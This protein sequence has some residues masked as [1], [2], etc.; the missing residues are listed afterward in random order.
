MSDLF[1]LTRIFTESNSPAIVQSVENKTFLANGINMLRET[2]ASIFEATV[3]LYSALLEAESTAK[4]NQNFADFFREYKNIINKYKN[5]VKSLAS[6]FVIN[7]ET[8]ADANKDILTID[9][10]ANVMALPTYVGVVYDNLL[11][12]EV[13]K[14]EPYKAFK[15]E[16]AFIGKLLQD[17]GPVGSE[18]AKAQVIATVCNNLTKEIEDGWLDKCIK[19]MTD[20]D[21][22]N[23]DGFAKAMYSKFVKD[24]SSEMKIDIGLV[25]QSKLAI[26]NYTSYIETISKSVEDFCDGLDK[27][28]EEIGSLF[29]RNKDHKL[30]IKTDVEGV[31][32]KTYRLNE[33]SFNQINT[34]ITTKISQT[35]ELCN[36]YLIALSIKMDCIYKYLQQCKDI[37]DTANHGVDNTPNTEEDPG[38]TG[39]DQ[40]DDTEDD[41]APIVNEEEPEDNLDDFEVPD[42]SG[43]ETADLSDSVQDNS[44]TEVETECYLFEAEIFQKER[45]VNKLI[46]DEAVL[47]LIAEDQSTNMVGAMAKST[48]S[49]LVAVIRNIIT[50]IGALVEKFKSTF[51]KNYEKRIKYVSDN[52]SRIEKAVIPDNWSIQRLKLDD[53]INFKVP[54]F[55][56]TDI[57]LLADRNKYLQAKYSSIMAPPKQDNESIKDMILNKCL[58]TTESKYTDSDRKDGLNFVLNQYKT[59]MASI[60]NANRVIQSAKNKTNNIVEK[61]PAQQEAATMKM[62]FEDGDNAPIDQ[63]AKDANAKQNPDTAKDSSKTDAVKQYF[64]INTAV[65]TAVMN[66]YTMAI[67]KH[68]NFLD[69]LA[70]LNGAAPKKDDSAQNNTAEPNKDENNNSK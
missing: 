53:L 63:A 33:Y 48:A 22:C 15:K 60:D 65:I 29:Y 2:D 55:N 54:D 7:I 32:D 6:Q 17:L 35:T 46:F 11:N 64:T 61:S 42:D 12:N 9:D 23:K 70:Q 43:E 57:P 59:A 69:K 45:L 51:T 41:N 37:V 68:L 20:C 62:Y 26:L 24:Q 4:E 19:K 18:E 66:I 56:E 52:K 50:Q 5:Q 14:V 30:P 36:L 28:A 39:D 8:F 21:D 47:Q 38:D 1:N 10:G 25:K 34:F 27:I 3:N 13:P 44:E 67:K 49:S 40:V 31:E 58:D 16:F